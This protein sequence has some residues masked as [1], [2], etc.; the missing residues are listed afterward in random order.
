M[1][2][3][4]PRRLKAAR[5]HCQLTQKQLGLRLGLDENTASARMNQYER[6][7]HAP[8][9][10]TMQRLARVLKVPVAYF[11]CDD[12]LL[13]RLICA[14]AGHSAEEQRRLLQRLAVPEHPSFEE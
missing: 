2:S 6:G 10:L 12:D 5:L 1:D 8:D 11:Y 13:A 7:K 3:V 4:L 9:Y 14:V